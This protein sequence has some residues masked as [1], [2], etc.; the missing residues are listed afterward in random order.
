MAQAGLVWLWTH[1]HRPG[2]LVVR[3]KP[4]C[5]DIMDMVVLAVGARQIMA[6]PGKV[7]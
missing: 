3:R 5:D 7:K 2:Q 1:P 4:K 6:K